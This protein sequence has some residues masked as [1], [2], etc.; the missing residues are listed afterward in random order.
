V[1][2]APRAVVFKAWTDPEHVGKWFGPRGFA[3]TTHSIDVRVGGQWRFDLRAPNGHVFPNVIEYVEIVP[4]E[5]LVF[6][7][8]TGREDDPER[9]RVTITFDEQNNKKTVMTMRQLHPTK[10]LRDAKIGFGAV[11]LGMQ[12][13]DKLAEHV[14]ANS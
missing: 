9:F 11:E 8:G 4:N 2:D 14:R 3:C 13:L 6:D 7:H 1:F 5:K 12:T 10:A